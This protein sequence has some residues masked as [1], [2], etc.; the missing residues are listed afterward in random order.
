MNTVTHG[1]DR[2]FAQ[3]QTKRTKKTGIW[4]LLKHRT[5]NTERPT[6]NG[7]KFGTATCR[8]SRDDRKGKFTGAN[9]G[10]GKGREMTIMKHRTLNIELPTSNG[11]REWFHRD[12]R[13]T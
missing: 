13:R 5:S 1:W 7:R 10:S 12:W 9:G 2:E 3:K 4:L 11:G 8:P 6:S